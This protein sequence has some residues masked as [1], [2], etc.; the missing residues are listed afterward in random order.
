MPF[1]VSNLGKVYKSLQKILVNSLCMNCSPSEISRKKRS[2]YAETT[3]IASAVV[4]PP[5][6]S[7]Y[8]VLVCESRNV[9]IRFF[10]I[11]GFQC[12]SPE[13]IYE[14]YGL[15]PDIDVISYGN[16]LHLCPA[17][18][19]E[20]DQSVCRE[21]HLHHHD[22][23]ENEE[24]ESSDL[25]MG[26]FIGTGGREGEERRVRKA[27]EGVALQVLHR[28][29]VSTVGKIAFDSRGNSKNE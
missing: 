1:R 10:L 18:V 25:A 2:Y 6:F 8:K 5:I 29:L 23:G 14:S 3:S 19:Y 16:F 12:L 21:G 7:V 20:L 26:M 22:F 9:P 15:T 24:E 27:R 4:P 28:R 17:I 11:P 13:E